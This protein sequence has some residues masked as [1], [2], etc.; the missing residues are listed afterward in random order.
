MLLARD[1][2]RVR[3]LERDPAPPQSNPDESWRG[4]KRRGV[5]QFRQLHGFLPRFREVLETELPDVAEALAADGALRFNRVLSLPE[6]LTGGARPGDERFM[7]LSGRRPMVEST[8]ARLAALQSAL[9]VRRGVAVQGLITAVAAVDI[10][11]VV[12]VITADGEELHA[13]VIVDAGGRRSPLPTWLKVIGAKPPIE[14]LE[15]SGFVYYCRHFRS[16]D[17]SV[18]PLFGPPV[19]PYDSISIATLPADNGTWG[20]GIVA[21][22]ANG[23]MRAARDRDVWERVVKS[24]PLVAHWLDGEAITG[25]DVMAAVHDRHRTFWVDGAPVATGVMAV[26]DAWACTNPSVGR[27]A[28]IGLLHA[29]A[30]RDVLRDGPVDDPLALARCWEEVTAAT[31]RTTGSRHHC[32]RPP[33]IGRVRRPDRRADVRN[34]RPSVVARTGCDAWGG[35]RSGPVAGGIDDRRAARARRGRAR[36]P[37]DPCQ[38][39]DSTVAAGI[40]RSESRRAGR[41]PLPLSQRPR[42]PSRA[43][44]HRPRT[45]GPLKAVTVSSLLDARRAGGVRPRRLLAVALFSVA[46]GTNVSTPL[47]LLY[48]DRLSLTNFT[49]TGLFAVYP[50][51]LLPALL[52]AGPASDVL[53]RRRLMMPGIVA[54]AVASLVMMLGRDHLAALYVGRLLLGAIS[55]VVFVAASAWL[56]EVEPTDDPLWPSRL[57]SMVLYGGFGAGPFVSGLLAQ[58]APWPLTLPY[59][60]HIG[61]VGAGLVAMTRV[62]ETVFAPRPGPIRPD[63][64][65]PPT[66]R[67]PFLEVV[68]PT[69]L[70]VFGFASLSLGLFPILLRPA[71]HGVALVATGIIAMLTAGAIFGAQRVVARIGIVRAAPLAMACGAV[72]CALGVVA[73]ATDWWPLVF[74]SALALGAGSGLA[75]TAGLRFVDVLTAPQTRGAMTGA[76]YAVAYA[77]MTMPALVSSIARTRTGYIAVLSTMTALSVA[78]MFWLRRRAPQIIV[79]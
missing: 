38:G 51:G 64:G 8:I 53:G 32:L 15:D 68:A 36:R 35:Q 11:H 23:T 28:S 62:P 48:Q 60:V 1:G 70:A 16:R 2:H 4:W 42:G 26:G 18:P 50:I 45:L 55:G 31:S 5:T 30:L 25:I 40:P 47:L 67:R 9:D 58:W 7:S 52:W 29:V 49:T 59:L 12:G 43:I 72:G 20:V 6:S 37:R 41:D 75:V 33:S 71:M 54:S 10:P 56:Q 21:S 69:A 34:G 46:F 14:E 66:A 17:G 13:D 39:V 77:A 27:G 76:F 57:T 79:V 61:L 78:A 22:A 73:F 24:Y 63:L 44:R 65:L 19:Q 3:I 74:P